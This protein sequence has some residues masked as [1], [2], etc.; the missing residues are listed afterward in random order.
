ML[1]NAELGMHVLWENPSKFGTKVPS[2]Q[3]QQPPPGFVSAGL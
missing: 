2:L 1:R 3:Y